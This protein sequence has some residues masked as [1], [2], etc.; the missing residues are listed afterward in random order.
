[1]A[2]RQLGSD[3]AGTT[4]DRLNSEGTALFSLIVSLFCF[5]SIGTPSFAGSLEIG[6]VAALPNADGGCADS[7][8]GVLV[9]MAG[10]PGNGTAVAADQEIRTTQTI[11][12]CH[13]L[14][15]NDVDVVGGELTLLAGHRIA[16]GNGFSVGP[17]AGLVAGIDP[18]LAREDAFLEDVSPASES[19][20]VA[21][22]YV[23]L[24]SLSM[25]GSDRLDHLVGY[26]SGGEAQFR[27]AFEPGT[28]SGRHRLI[29][30]VRQDDGSYLA[31]EGNQELTV[32]SGWH[33]VEVDWI[34]ASAVG[35]G[36]GSMTV[37]LDD[38][39]SRTSCTRLS[40]GSLPPPENAAAR[41]DSVR[42]GAQGIDENTSGSLAMD[43]FVSRRDGPIGQ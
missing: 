39:G 18:A 16:F 23:N 31:T 8:C 36:D 24:D 41:I 32:P 28:S 10:C 42:W 43:E 40:D 15:A 37:C 38:D 11:E 6:S 22:F 13:T 2:S 1:M 21:R 9:D 17:D 3:A 30:E 7:N 34:A 14:I 26:G 33:A 19:R 20:Y 4:G 5:I 29:F 35:A 25:S 27:V 12:G